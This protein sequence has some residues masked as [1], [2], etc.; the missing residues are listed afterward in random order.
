MLQSSKSCRR[1]AH[2][3]EP[4]SF[5]ECWWP[6]YHFSCKTMPQYIGYC[7]C[8][9]KLACMVLWHFLTHNTAPLWHVFFLHEIR[10]PLKVC[11]FQ[12][13]RWGC[14]RSHVLTSQ[15]ITNKY[16][17]E[18]C[19]Y[20]LKATVP[21]GVMGPP[22]LRYG[23]C[24]GTHQYTTYKHERYNHTKKLIF[25]NMIQLSWAPWPML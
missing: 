24:A 18:W 21:K 3:W 4:W 12:G 10:D 25:F 7:L 19:V 14:R 11:H 5:L 6:K 9:N 22:S 17:Y 23:Y 1:I 13:H 16:M 2:L 20:L 15:N 8:N